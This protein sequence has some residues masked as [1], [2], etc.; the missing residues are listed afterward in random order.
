MYVVV[1]IGFNKA[2]R[3]DESVER[4]SWFLLRVD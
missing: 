4:Q 2:V 1:E 3:Q